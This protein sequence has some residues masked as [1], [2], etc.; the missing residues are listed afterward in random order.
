MARLSTNI[1]QKLSVR[2]SLMITLSVAVLLTAA[3]LVM[4]FFS[5][6]AVKHEA[7]MKA[8]QTLETTGMRIDNVLLSVEQSAGNVYW[9][10]LAD[11][12]RPER[13]DTYCR[14]LL[15]TNPYITGV[16]IAMQPYYYRQHGEFFMCY[17]RRQS[18]GGIFS[19]HSPIL[20][21]AQFGQEPYTRQE[22]YTLPVD[23]GRPCWIGALKDTDAEGEAVCTFSLP[24]YDRTGGRV[25]VLAVDMALSL[26][27]HIIHEAKPSP[28][29]YCTLLGR[30]GSYIIHPDT[31]KLRNQKIG[32]VLKQNADQTFREA[33][34]AMMAGQTGYRAFRLQGVDYHVFYKPFLQSAV[35]GRVTEDL[36]WS[37]GIIYPDDDILGDYKRLLYIVLV[38]VIAGLLLLLVLS[39]VIAHRHLLPL[40]L[41]DRSAQRIAD[42]HYDE[43]IPDSR[44]SDEIGRLQDHFQ[45]MQQALASHVG[46]L[47][48]INDTLQQRGDNLQQAYSKARQADDMKT[49]F[50]HN[51]TNQMLQPSAVIMHDVQQLCEHGQ[52]ITPEETDRQADE[53][54]QQGE[55]ITELLNNLLNTSQAV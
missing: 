19:S 20:K 31:T 22:W 44:H 18:S 48:Q 55:T 33:A 39:Q 43:T 41:L 14:K 54:Q 27:S 25:G 11:L 21:T 4:F 53:I 28:N 16:T 51:M 49:A 17:Y 50:L 1:T 32:S 8:R 23:S 52:T 24:I 10:L 30:D 45:Q 36:G 15:E 7:L 3:M 6:K 34:H 9:S 47:Q 46:Q 37:I 29:S 38:I 12:D 2:L 35:V 26:L 40:R 13:M 42:G 5:R